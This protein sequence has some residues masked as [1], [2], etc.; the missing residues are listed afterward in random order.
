MPA[1]KKKLCLGLANPVGDRPVAG[2]LAG[3]LAK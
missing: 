2:R 1:G 3:L